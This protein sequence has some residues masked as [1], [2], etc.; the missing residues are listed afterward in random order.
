MIFVSANLFDCRLMHRW[1]ACGRSPVA[2]GGIGGLPRAQSLVFAQPDAI[3]MTSRYMPS[4]SPGY[5]SS[6]WAWRSEQ[7]CP[8]E[9]CRF[10]AFWIHDVCRFLSIS[11]N[12]DPKT[13][14]VMDEVKLWRTKKPRSQREKRGFMDFAGLLRMSSWCLR[15]ESNRHA[16]RR[17]ILSQVRLPIPPQRLQAGAHISTSDAKLTSVRGQAGRH[18]ALR[19]FQRMISPT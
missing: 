2:T 19:A 7:R 15:P 9:E 17:L 14:L 5:R 18:W 16:F 6:P 12:M 3:G 4:P 11:E 13:G 8:T 10:W 1:E